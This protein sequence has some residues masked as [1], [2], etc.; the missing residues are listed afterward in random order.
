MLLRTPVTLGVD[1]FGNSRKLEKLVEAF[2]DACNS[3][4]RGNRQAPKSG[5]LITANCSA[6]ELQRL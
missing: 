4:S 2:F 6:D 1:G 5:L 3:F